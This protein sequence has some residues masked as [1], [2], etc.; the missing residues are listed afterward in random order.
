MAL[1]SLL[2]SEVSNEGETSVKGRIEVHFSSEKESYLLDSSSVFLLN[3]LDSE[4]KLQAK[5]SILKFLSGIPEMK[6]KRASKYGSPCLTF[7]CTGEIDF[8][9]SHEEEGFSEDFGT[10]NLVF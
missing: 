1:F 3:S 4:G 5:K 2:V 7:Y 6:K 8:T 10:V 9:R